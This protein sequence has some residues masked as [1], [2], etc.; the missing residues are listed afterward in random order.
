[1]AA[2]AGNDTSRNQVFRA[3]AVSV[4]GT[5]D[6]VVGSVV[7]LLGAGLAAGRGNRDA[8]PVGLAIAVVGLFLALTG[9]GRMTA[10]LE[11]TATSVAWT[12]AFSRHELPVSELEDAALVEK[13]SPA[14]GAAWAGFLGGGFFGVLAWWLVELVAATVSS[15]PTIGAFDLV[16][17]K[18]HGAPVEVRPISSWSTR[19]SHSQADEALQAVRTAITSSAHITPQHLR[20]LRHDAWEP[21]EGSSQS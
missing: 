11:V 18:H 2:I 16:L 7:V 6:L 10:R 1:M 4:A 5:V 12:W 20:I 3:R 21:P 17:S 19:S 8:V 14:S 13:G 15:E 9:L